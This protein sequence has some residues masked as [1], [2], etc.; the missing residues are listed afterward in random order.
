M[1]ISRRILITLTILTGIMLSSC[2]ETGVVD[3]DHCGVCT[4]DNQCPGTSEC[5][6][7]ICVEPEEPVADCEQYDWLEQNS[8]WYCWCEGDDCIGTDAE[9]PWSCPI[10]LLDDSTNDQVCGIQ[11]H[12]HF[13]LADDTIFINRLGDPPTI[14]IDDGN[15]V[16][17]CTQYV[18][19]SPLRFVRSETRIFAD[20]LDDHV[21]Q[22][23]YRMTAPAIIEVFIRYNEDSPWINGGLAFTYSD[24]NHGAVR[25]G[26]HP[27]ESYPSGTTTY[28]KLEAHRDI[29][30]ELMDTWTGS[31]VLY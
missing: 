4:T 31:Q 26:F 29:N 7:G 14:V 13:W 12:D 11:C 30:N 28:W 5:L 10:E 2:I 1:Y 9:L 3:N 16:V 8:T 24:Q 25:Y 20:P 19:I 15:G 6:D 18:D 21:V 17:T 22:I 23:D 27:E